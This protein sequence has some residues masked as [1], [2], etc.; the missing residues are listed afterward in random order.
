MAKRLSPL[1]V[2]ERKVFD[3]AQQFVVSSF[4]GRGETQ[5]QE[6]GNDLE[7]AIQL[8]SADPR[9]CI[10]AVSPAGRSIIL[11]RKSWEFWKARASSGAGI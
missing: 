8:C 7:R 3:E 1:E 11:D 10:Y 6:C 5:R 4:R 9:A 2:F